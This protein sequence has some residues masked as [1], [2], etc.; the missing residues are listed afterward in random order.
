MNPHL[1]LT[2]DEV[3]LELAGLLELSTSDRKFIAIH[4]RLNELIDQQKPADLHKWAW[5]H[6]LLFLGLQQHLQADSSSP[7]PLQPQLPKAA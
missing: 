3:A 6:E 5:V 4:S 2:L 7:I 1:P